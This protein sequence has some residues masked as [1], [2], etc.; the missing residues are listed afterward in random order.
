MAK[1]TMLKL[2]TTSKMN[3]VKINTSEIIMARIK[4]F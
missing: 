3:L 4:V 2:L 1:P